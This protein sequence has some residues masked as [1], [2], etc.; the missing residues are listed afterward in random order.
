RAETTRAPGGNASTAAENRLPRRGDRNLVEALGTN[1]SR[2]HLSNALKRLSG[3]ETAAALVTDADGGVLE[4]DAGSP[5]LEHLALDA[6]G[7]DH[8]V[9]MLTAIAELTH[10]SVT[11]YAVMMRYRPVSVKR[12]AEPT[13]VTPSAATPWT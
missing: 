1:R 12:P 4:N 13:G 9:A 8:P 10:S 11:S 6:L 2:R 3:V 7:A 5:V